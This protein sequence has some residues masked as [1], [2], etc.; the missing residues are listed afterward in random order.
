MHVEITPR[1]VIWFL[2]AIHCLLW[3]W[4]FV[5]GWSDVNSGDHNLLTLGMTA[6]TM[7]RLSAAGYRTGCRTNDDFVRRLESLK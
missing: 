5:R 2:V 3:G 6:R 7:N 4:G 1:K